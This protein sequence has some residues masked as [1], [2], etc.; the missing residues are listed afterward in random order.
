MPRT[1][2]DW[3]RPNGC[4]ESSDLSEEDERTPE[5]E[6]GVG[7]VYGPGKILNS[8]GICVSRVSLPQFIY[9]KI[10]TFHY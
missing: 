9:D 5:R 7:G 6:E 8:S 2:R 1:D 10:N 3:R 4:T